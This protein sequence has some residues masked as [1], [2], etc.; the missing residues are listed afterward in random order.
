MIKKDLILQYNYFFIV[1]LAVCHL[2]GLFYRLMCFFLFCFFL[3]VQR[4]RCPV[5]QLRRVLV[6]SA[7]AKTHQV[8]LLYRKNSHKHSFRGNYTYKVFDRNMCIC[9]K[10]TGNWS[11]LPSNDV[12]V[13][14]EPKIS[15]WKMPGVVSWALP[16]SW[17]CS[18]YCELT[19]A[20]FAVVKLWQYFVIYL[21]RLKHHQ[22]EFRWVE[23]GLKY[24]SFLCW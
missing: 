14:N 22:S 17:C 7:R 10:I 13:V 19:S 16:T 21:V 11:E 20:E 5:S 23:T 12:T 4:G 18:R 2:I 6:Y 15:C 3:N 1:R 24:I 8:H 9:Q